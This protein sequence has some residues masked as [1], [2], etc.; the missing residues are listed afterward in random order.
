MIRFCKRVPFHRAVMSVAGPSTS[1]E[2]QAA[3]RSPWL[4]TKA[5]K[6]D[7][8]QPGADAAEAEG[9]RGDN[10]V[11]NILDPNVLASMMPS[12]GLQTGLLQSC[13]WL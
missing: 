11:G 9:N 2:F 12:Q 5:G 10:V 7:E 3:Q 8:R 6:E 1:G 13:Q 4:A